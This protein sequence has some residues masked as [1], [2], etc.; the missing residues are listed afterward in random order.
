MRKLPFGTRTLP[1]NVAGPLK[2]L[3]VVPAAVKFQRIWAAGCGPGR[4][5]TVVTLLRICTPDTPG[6]VTLMMN[7]SFALPVNVRVCFTRLMLLMQITLSPPLPVNVVEVVRFPIDWVQPGVVLRP[8]A[9]VDAFRQS[10]GLLTL[11]S[12]HASDRFSCWIP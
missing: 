2:K 7:L 9:A 3:T 11:G 6:P 10:P 12:P 4:F 5:R 8:N 1:A